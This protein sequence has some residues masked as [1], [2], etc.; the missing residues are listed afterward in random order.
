MSDTTSVLAELMKVIEN[1]RANFPAGS[2]TTQLLEG[3]VDKI[4]AKI[5]EE[6]REVVLAAAEPGAEGRAHFIHEAADL[7]Y[8]LWVMMGHKAVTLADVEFELARR[9]G[10]SGIDEK[11][12]RAE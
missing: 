9:F 2:Y 6:A 3:G 1:R 12:A 10:I 11:A 5:E 4:G 7:I 8:H